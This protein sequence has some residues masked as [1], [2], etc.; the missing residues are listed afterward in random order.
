MPRNCG[1]IVRD[2]NTGRILKVAL[3]PAF[4]KLPIDSQY[5]FLCES[6][7]HFLERTKRMKK[8]ARR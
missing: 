4:Y 6:K 1:K 3:K 5:D 8:L 2:S 7:E